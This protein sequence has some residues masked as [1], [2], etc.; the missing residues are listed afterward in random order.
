[1]KKLCALLLALAR[2]SPAAGRVAYTAARTPW[3]TK[4]ASSPAS[5]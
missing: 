5:C 2:P 3:W 1:M 4:T